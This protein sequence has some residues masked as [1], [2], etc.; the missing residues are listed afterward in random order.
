MDS[1]LPTP[2]RRDTVSTTSSDKLP[3]LPSG[4]WPLTIHGNCSRCGHHHKA[5]MIQISV[6][7]GICEASHVTCERCDQKWLT[8][9]GVNTTQISLLS[10]ITRDL[11]HGEINFRYTLFSM[12]RSAA[13]IASP[14][15]LSNVPE[16]PSPT[17]SR[18]SSG[19][20]RG[21]QL[22][23]ADTGI[24]NTS[25][26]DNEAATTSGIDANPSHL[27][28]RIVKDYEA[29]SR[30]LLTKVKRKLKNTIG[31]LRKVQ[32]K[33]SRQAQE[34]T[35]EIVDEHLE[36][37]L[38]HALSEESVN[39]DMASG[40]G[41]HA[42]ENPAMTAAQAIEDLKSFDKEVIR[43]MTSQQRKDWIREHITAFK[44][45]CSHECVCKRRHSASS[46][47]ERSSIRQYRVPSIGSS[48]QR[49]ALGQ[50]GSQFD[51]LPGALFTHTGP[52]TISATRI[53]EADTAVDRQSTAPS[54][55]HSRLDSTQSAHR[56]RSPRPASLLQA[57]RSWQ[58]SRNTRGQRNS[59]DSMLAG[60]TV[61]SS[62]RGPARLSNTSLAPTLAVGN[63]AQE[64]AA[65]SEPV[66]R[67]DAP[68]SSTS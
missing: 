34:G 28:D 44:C 38:P 17:P 29:S 26:H 5:V 42:H 25:V 41:E 8:I 7:E 64:Q 19:Q 68:A 59:M 11:D 39:S 53:S 54:P 47:T 48:F 6:V 36:P 2:L 49:V 1:P 43:N 10:T 14:T 30:P 12:V 22:R 52:L 51:V 45:R 33:K 27:P 31:M 55:R 63:D 65:A 24:Q 9:G 37:Q 23:H 4:R 61:R 40:D 21:T 56:S 62:W 20:A 15:A 46:A 3:S 67:E 66:V 60:S 50:M 18:S 32:T 35:R 57:R 13:S 58:P 16:D